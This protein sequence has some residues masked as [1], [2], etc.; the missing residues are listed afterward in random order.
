MK[1]FNFFCSGCLHAFAPPFFPGRNPHFFVVSCGYGS[2]VFHSLNMAQWGNTRQRAIPPSSLTE[3]WF[4][5]ALRIGLPRGD[6]ELHF[7]VLLLCY[8][9]LSQKPIIEIIEPH[10]LNDSTALGFAVFY[11][12]VNT[13]VHIAYLLP[14]VI[15]A[16]NGSAHS[17]IETCEIPIREFRCQLYFFTEIKSRKKFEKYLKYVPMYIF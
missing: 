16:E 7:P 1:L 5:S 17:C 6:L 2:Y 4:L 12:F 3:E 10:A 13:F 8:H 11:D 9:A 15:V 14:V